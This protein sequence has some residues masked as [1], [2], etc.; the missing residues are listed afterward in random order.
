MRRFLP[1]LGLCAVSLLPAQQAA[2]GV[3]STS[4]PVR[5]DVLALA[6][7]GDALV[8]ARR[9][10]RGA[11]RIE[12]RRPGQPAKLVLLTE[13]DDRNAG[14]T[15]SASTETVAVGLNDDLDDSPAQSRLWVGPPAG[16]LREVAGCSR[17]F[18]P[19][20]TAVDGPRVAW[21]DGGCASIPGRPVEVGPASVALGNVDPAIP[22]K[23][24][25]IPRDSV[26]I[27]IALRGDSG[28][29]GILR[30]TFFGFSG[31]VRPFGP[32]GLGEARESEPGG[33]LV[34]VGLLADG[35]AALAR[36]A[37]PESN[38]RDL[39][40]RVRPRCDSDTVLLP[41]GATTRR[42]LQTGG[43]LTDHELYG[44]VDTTVAGERIVS[45]VSPLGGRM[46]RRPRPVAVTSVRPDGTDLKTIVSGSY[47][48]PRG[49]AANGAR[50]GWW[51]RR[52]AGGTELVV[53]DGPAPT[54]KACTLRVLTR[55][56][57]LRAGRISLRVRCPRGCTGRIVD[58]TQCGPEGLRR[59]ALARG[60]SRLRVRVP[61]RTR[62]RGRV[63]LRLAIDGGPARTAVVR[64]RR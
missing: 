53:A 20:S 41:P 21:A 2:A 22:V 47:R 58:D 24:H 8:I 32:D 54:I 13:S 36:S 30:P 27:G 3:V 44:Q 49:L 7:S 52:C 23:R 37:D 56:A 39:D 31:D 16:P 15:L 64:L 42:T 55:R 62:R 59:F 40:D 50:I 60:T 57:R 4:A 33:S 18:L 43:C 48:G 26:S 6:F 11:V 9:P 34:P 5:G 38:D 35:T 46:G 10:E 45:L 61:R 14:V 19:P 28:L 17:A 12:L 29:T 63:L 1:V 25:P 51:Q